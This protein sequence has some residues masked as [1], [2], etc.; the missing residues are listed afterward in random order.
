MKKLLIIAVLAILLAPVCLQ[1]QSEGKIS[2]TERRDQSLLPNDIYAGYGL[3]SVYFW[4][5]Q[6]DASSTVTPG[7]FFIGYS[8]SLGKVIDVG[9]QASFTPITFKYNSASYNGTY[10]T[11]ENNNYWQGLATLRFSYLSKPMFR[12]YSGIG[13]GVTMNY[14]TDVANGV[15]TSGQKLLPAGQMT[16]L[17]FRV[18]R[19]L[20]GF[21]EFGIGTNGIIILGMSYRFP[22]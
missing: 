2:L 6:D 4:A 20:S 13:I 8:R 21:G 19:A 17:G 12:M 16:F 10:S 22:D 9:F 5:N 7:T 1:A 3:G 14:Y 11:E 15:T 18:G